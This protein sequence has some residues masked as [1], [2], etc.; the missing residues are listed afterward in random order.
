MVLRIAERRGWGDTWATWERLNDREQLDML[1][2]EWYR[3][4]RIQELIE[5]LAEREWYTAEL[6]TKLSVERL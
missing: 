6:Y 3:R 1:A 2:R 4:D 5:Q